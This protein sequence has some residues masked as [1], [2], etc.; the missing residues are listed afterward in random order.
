MKRSFRDNR[1]LWACAAALSL[2]LCA[3]ISLHALWARSLAAQSHAAVSTPGLSLPGPSP[4]HGYNPRNLDPRVSPCQDFY[5]YAVGGWRARNPIPADYPE[6]G[7]VQV[8]TRRNK[9]LLRGILENDAGLRQ[10]ESSN[11]RKLGDFYE[12]CMNTKAVEAEGLKPL[13]PEFKRIAAIHNLPSLEAGIERLQSLGVDAPFAFA[14]QQDYKNSSE[15]TGVA[16]QAGLGLPNCTY[17]TQQDA[18]SKQIRSQY[19]EHAVKLFG[20]LGDS[21]SLAAAEAASVMK[22]ET[23]L[24]RASMTPVELRN[25]EAVYHRMAL[26]ELRALTPD[27]SWQA[28]FHETGHPHLTSINVGQP[29]FFRAINRA[30]TGLPLSDWKT[31]LRWQLIDQAAP[32][33]SDAFVNEDFNFSRLLTGAT[34]LQ[35]RWLRCVN[36]IDGGMGMALGQQYVKAAFPPSSKADAET[37]VDNLIAALSSDISTLPWMGPDTKTFALA[38]LEAMQRKIGYPDQWRDYS[39]LRIT[40]GSYVI[41][42]LN[43]DRFEFNRLLNK[44]GKPVDRAEWE[45]TP[46][47]VNAYYDHSM[48]DIVFPSGILQPPFFDPGAASALNYGDTGATIGHE[49][50]HGFDDEGRQFDARGNLKN[51]WTPQDLAQFNRRATCI[52]NEFD[53]YVVDDQLHENGKLVEGESIADLGGVVIAY[54][55]FEKSMAGE[56]RIKIG[57]FTPEQ[58][59]FLGYAESW[60]ENI[61]PELERLY[62]TSDP[63]PIARFRVNG[64]LS[65]MPAFAAA[66]GCKAGDPMVRPPGQQCKIW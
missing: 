40:R 5:Q 54:D 36:S 11:E 28:Y 56:P 9:E 47:T 25:P 22:T 60:E 64:P 2:A 35:P 59:F 29:E 4:L 10:S 21:P 16:W 3:G 45:M 61:R 42:V 7:V 43:A 17:Y 62:V 27:F 65:N 41:N 52:V 14:S 32:Y 58:L 66:W 57:G 15:V 38:K 51:W 30:L 44:I 34:Q 20:L 19:L 39:A 46:P 31:Y 1:F 50:T 12:T 33:L 37:M 48:N 18:K 24:A 8:V 6:W 26:T 13:E 63:H 49:M 23:M 53:G 55:A